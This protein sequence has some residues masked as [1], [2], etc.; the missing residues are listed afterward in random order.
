LSI[1]GASLYGR[2]P[3]GQRTFAVVREWLADPAFPVD[4]LVTH[5][6]PLEEYQVALETALAGVAAGAVKVVFEG[7]VAPLRSQ[8]DEEGRHD[9]AGDAPVLLHST[10]ARA[11]S[12]R[13]G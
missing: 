9:E 11:R 8:V 12:A 7:S 5:R 13:S 1:L 2:E 3:S 6:F 4:G 10:A